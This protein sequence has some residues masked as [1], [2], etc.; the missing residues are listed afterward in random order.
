MPQ[1]AIAART[2]TAGIGPARLFSMP[3]SINVLVY[4]I[5]PDIMERCY[6]H[7][8]VCLKSPFQRLGKRIDWATQHQRSKPFRPTAQWLPCRA[9]EQCTATQPSRHIFAFLRR[10]GRT[11]PSRVPRMQSAMSTSARQMKWGRSLCPNAEVALS[12]RAAPIS[13]IAARRA[14]RQQIQPRAEAISSGPPSQQARRRAEGSTEVA[15]SS[16]SVDEPATLNSTDEDAAARASGSMSASLLASIDEAYHG[17]TSSVHDA[18][19][20]VESAWQRS[21]PGK[22]WAAY[23]QV[24]RSVLLN[25]E[26]GG[27]SCWMLMRPY[28]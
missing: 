22:W 13:A 16:T 2:R 1:P 11:P 10:A 9:R 27:W 6:W 21:P 15:A 17:V 20:A 4:I 19:V 12:S 26:W 7:L 23:T 24:Q 25:V 28:L 3:T 8:V 18:E 5:V 14:Q